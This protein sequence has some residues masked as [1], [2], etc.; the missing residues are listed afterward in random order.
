MFIVCTNFIAA[1]SQEKKFLSDIYD[2]LENT[3]VFEVNQ[4]EGHVPLVPYHNVEEALNNKRSEA[5][6]F[7]SL[8]GTWKFHFANTPESI[9]AGFFAEAFNDKK[10]DTIHVPSNWEMQGFGDPLFRNVPASFIAGRYHSWVVSGDDLPQ[11]FNVTCKDE[12]GIIMGIS[13]KDYDVRGLQFHPES[14][15]TEYGIDI[16]GNWINN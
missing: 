1:S 10:W 3:S 2:Y 16:L 4:V 9:P 14:V 5:A 11:C 7:L 6:G 15:L 12:N 8:N 13:H